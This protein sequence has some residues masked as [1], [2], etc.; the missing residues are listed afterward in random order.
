MWRLEQRALLSNRPHTKN[1]SNIE[2]IHINNF[3]L[4]TI[5]NMEGLGL[6]MQEQ[7]IDV[8]KTF[9]APSP[10]RT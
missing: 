2:Y 5:T 10:I 7:A 8:I 4:L 6:A 3:I 1:K 9:M